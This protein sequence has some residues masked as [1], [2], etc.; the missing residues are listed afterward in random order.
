MGLA[1]HLSKN[2][3]SFGR[4]A[5][6]VSV[7]SVFTVGCN[8]VG[9]QVTQGSQQ[10]IESLCG[11]NDDPNA[12]GPKITAPPKDLYTHP[13]ITLAGTCETGKDVRIGGGGINPP[14]NTTCTD[15][16][17]SQALTLVSPDGM[18]DINVSQEG[19]G[20]L[21][22]RCF[23]LDTLPPKVLI[24]TPV[25][26]Y[27]NST[28]ISVI[29]ECETGFDVN[30]E[31]TGGGR[32]TT[33]CP[34]GR[35]QAQFPSTGGD[36][37]KTIVA[38]QTDRAGN[39]GT[40]DQIYIVDTTVPVVRIVTPVANTIVK[41]AVQVNGTCETGLPVKIAGSAPN[42]SVTTTCD[43]GQFAAE[44]KIHPRE[45][46]LYIT[47]EQ[48]DL[49]GNRGWDQRNVIRDTTPPAIQITGP[50]VGTVAR[51]GLTV[52]GTC[53]PDL[54]VNLSGTGLSAP[55]TITC[56]S[57]NWSQAITFS[58]G[59]GVKNIIASQT[60]LAGNMGSSTRDFMKDNTPPVITITAPAANTATRSTIALQ[61]TCETG[62]SVSLSGNI[63]ATTT[64][65]AGGQFS[66]TVTLTSPDGTKNVIASQTD[67]IGNVGSANRNFVLDTTAPVITITGP[68]A[69]TPA[70]TGVTVVGSCTTGL[71]IAV[72]GG[73]SSPSTAT[74][75]NGSFSIPVV[76][77]GADGT[78]NVLLSQTDSVGNTGTASRDFI[79]DTTP[80][81][82]TITAP[83]PL[84]VVQTGVTLQGECT[85]GLTVSISGT[86]VSAPSSAACN[87]GNYSTPVLF[88]AG[89]GNKNV[90]A[91]QTD[92][93]G[94]TGSANRDFVRNNT[95]PTIQIT[96]PQPNTTTQ[97]QIVIV[98]ICKD[99]LNV[100]IGGQIVTPIIVQC[101][102]GNFSAT[103]T[104]TAP[105]GTKNVTAS[106]TD[107]AGNVGTD[108][109]NFILDTLAP[110]I[111]ITAP[112]A[113]TVA[114]TGVTLQGTCTTGLTVNISGAGVNAPSTTTCPAG[115]FSTNILF[116]VS[117]GIKNVIA[118]QSDAAGN[119]GADN[120]NFIKDTV[121]P[122]IKITQPAAMTI[123]RDGLTLQ[124]TCTNGLPINISGAGVAAPSAA[125]CASGTFS[126][127]ILFS[128]SDGVKNVIAAQTDTAGNTGSDNRNFVRDTTAPAITIA[129]PAAN[130]ATRSALNISGSCETGLQVTMGGQI[131]SPVTAACTAGNYTVTVTLA[132]PDGTKNVTASQTDGVGN[133]GTAN[134]NFV[135]TTAAPTITIA[136][137][138]ANTVT[139]SSL[140]IS[141][142][143]TNGLP[144]MISGGVSGPSQAACA[145]STYSANITL[146]N[147]D[148]T[149]NVVVSQ[150]DNLGNS[151]SDNRN[152]ILDTAMP[153]V[154]ITLPA[155]NTVAQN[156]VTVVGTCETG[157]QV[158]LSGGI[159][160]TTAGCNNGTFSAPVTFTSPDGTKNVVA[161]QT[162]AAGN[163][164]SANRDFIRDTTGPVLAITAPAA[165]TAT[166]SQI[167]VVGTCESGLNVTMGGQIT[168][169]VTTACANGGFTATVTLASPDGTKNVTAS[170]T[171]AVGNTGTANRNFA[172]TTA[173]PTITIAQPAPNTITRSGLTI[174][175]QCAN[176]IPVMISGGVSAPSQATCTNSAYSA[177]ITLSNGDGTKNVVVTQTDNVG[178]SA[179]DNRNFI[180]DTTAPM[181]A[182][183][184]PSA[185]TVAQFGVTVTG[186]CESG[187]Q[188]FLTGGITPTSTGCNGGI[189]SSPVT[190]SNG[191]GTKNV[192]ATQT[193]AAGNVGSANRDFV[194][195]TS[196]PVITITSPAAGTATRSTIAL[197]GTCTD[198]FTINLTGDISPSMAV[199]LG[200]SWTATVTLLPPD[201][202]KNVVASQ[203][204]MAGNTGT[205]NRSFQLVTAAPTIRITA[206]AVNTVTQGGLT[207]SGTCVNGLTVTL[208]GDLGAA[209]TTAC[210]GTFSANINLAGADGSKTITASQT[211]AAGNIGSDS[212]TFIKD[213][214]SPVVRF[215]TPAANTVAGN[216]LTVAGTC[217]TGLQV[218]LSGTGLGTPG[219][220][221]CPAGT[222]N[223]TITFSAGDGTKNIVATQTDAAG[224]S[225]SD[226]RNFIKD[227]TAPTIRIVTPLVNAVTNSGLTLT[228][229]CE[230]GLTVTIAGTG[231]SGGARTTNCTNAAF[232][233]A[234]TLASPDGTKNITVAQT[235]NGGNTGSDNRNFILDATAPRVTITSP[236]NGSQPGSTFP[237]LGACEAGLA[238]NITG[239]ITGPSTTTCPAGGTY[240]VSI[241][242]AAGNGSKR[243]TAAQTD[244][245]GNTGSD[246]A[247]YTVTPRPNATETFMADA[248]Q[249]K[250][251]ILFI[252]DNSVSMETEQ[253][254]LGTKFPSFVAE[255]AGLDWQVGITTTDCSNGPHG[256]CGSLLNMT[257]TASNILTP[258]VAGYQQVFNSTIQRPETPGCATLGTCPS[259]LEEA[260]KA[261]STSIDKRNTNN[262]GFFRSDAALAIV[263]LTDEDEQSDGQLPTAVRPQTV[264]NKVTT[265]FGAN[266]K[267]KSYAITIL[268]GDTACLAQQ[269]AQQ[270]GIA[271]YGT[272]AMELARLTGGQSVS[273]CAPDYSVTLRQIG[274]DLR[275]LT[276]AVTL[277]RAPIPSSVQVTFTPAQNITWTVSGN[278]ILFSQPVSAGTKID[279]YYEY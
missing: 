178:N 34:N 75:N 69:N 70:Q 35:F 42:P 223:A 41:N 230:T 229:T 150:T 7:T 92:A 253:A 71:P 46:V 76:F 269:S 141:G 203:T 183:T 135:L 14:V 242:L 252:D 146:S 184:G 256:I 248:G 275:K 113:N 109:R 245:A 154:T 240:S 161:S 250:V 142:A 91:S 278:T 74:C 121:G 153:V 96:G 68:A 118:S 1:F 58:N 145:N 148:G 209:V 128:N 171:D 163:T 159:T 81:R 95:P 84:T 158:S 67:G 63:S 139:R 213:T 234:I 238:L 168:A 200:G 152:F 215:S 66:A 105:D 61:G 222:F 138:A 9:F 10:Q 218:Q 8:D 11:V 246:T 167:N 47:A 162:D 198:G 179:S 221:S 114:Q 180:L 247:N 185:G 19:V 26:P 44:V 191:D 110:A 130:T 78:K 279:V 225:G 52:V 45:A 18:K 28:F 80:P 169:A 175:G 274:Q 17:F 190:F 164:G 201:G 207:V 27:S 271:Y 212:R 187:L 2:C 15:G 104:L 53:T 208:T 23:F 54:P 194:K 143:C 151:G 3:L 258:N 188:V 254:A 199:C 131:V 156:G 244:A 173:A 82:I 123:A 277:T 48:V 102:N 235:D 43:N 50:A 32:L 101:L 38:T 182:I 88:T 220:V 262:A 85:D 265:A 237:L 232:S 267:F 226:N 132:S 98:G 216:T 205:A 124:G 157:L 86:G 72:S 125:T 79:K 140:T 196:A 115:T 116:S 214:T 37:S 211:D 119:T 134:R 108:N 83:A 149:K 24:T 160:S 264:V 236:G 186:T 276:Q 197:Q 36:G 147:G 107:V 126:T 99:G 165:G 204:D 5:I 65:C 20:N 49:A 206:P 90:V 59:D 272:F 129:A 31:Q 60:D 270:N 251:D 22:K 12:P 195:D 233:S 87:N 166:R 33:Q 266:K 64:T 94:N 39:V 219:P 77:S 170:Q 210:N 16:Q 73:I 231:L 174:S 127:N 137:P 100:N 117:D 136:Q 133:V 255:L 259:G 103:I 21:G 217:E 243:V 261:A 177:N 51:A 268:T 97:G 25:N 57:G 155:A 260:M 13:A 263:V 193:D 224:N 30:L 228:G 106:Q 93:A 273:I 144:I 257:G 122:D 40:D 89:D 172:L 4:S 227:T 112:A 56:N 189:F 239:D 241:T 181:V 62:L 202:A 111:A 192:V 55:M 29:G 176:G 6:L 249:G 120:R